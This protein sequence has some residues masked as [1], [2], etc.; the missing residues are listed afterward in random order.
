MKVKSQEH[1]IVTNGVRQGNKGYFIWTTFHGS[2]KPAVE[3]SY[4]LKIEF[5][6][7]IG[8]VNS[9]SGK[10]EVAAKANDTEYGL[11][12]SVFTKDLCRAMRFSKSLESGAVV[13]NRAV[14]T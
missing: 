13:I 1:I 7:P 12:A 9:L 10:E 3:D 11:F 2:N 5:F 4:I 6:S 14:P 8:Q